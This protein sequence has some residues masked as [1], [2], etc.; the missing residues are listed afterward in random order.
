M[1]KALE[2]RYFPRPPFEIKEKFNFSC[3]RN[4]LLFIITY[5]L[6]CIFGVKCFE[7]GGWSNNIMFILKFEILRFLKYCLYKLNSEGLN[8]LTFNLVHLLDLDH[9]VT[10]SL[11][12]LDLIYS[13][14]LPFCPKIILAF[15][16][17]KFS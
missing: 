12:C 2:C 16:G 14:C 7:Y 6:L 8:I 11:L 3:N 1:D 9:S 5:H 17:Y 4:Y 10:L 15:V 13:S